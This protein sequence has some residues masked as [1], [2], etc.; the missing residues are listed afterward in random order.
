M[1]SFYK[2]INYLKEQLEAD[3]DVNTICHGEVNDIDID[4]NNIYPLAHIEV[5]GASFPTGLVQVNFTINV[6]DQR[7]L[8]KAIVTDKFLKNDNELDN[9]NTCLAVMNRLIMRLKLQSN[10]LD[11]ELAND[12][13]PSPVQFAFTNTLDGWS[14]DLQLTITN[15]VEVC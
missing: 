7:N 11:I 10:D 2:I 3:I 9:L 4:K 12:P 13:T 8:S 14:C 6:I 5:T 1:N 15:N